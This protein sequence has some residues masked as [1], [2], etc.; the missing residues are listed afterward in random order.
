MKVAV[1]IFSLFLSVCQAQ[2]KYEMIFPDSIGWNV[3][4]E[5]QALEFTIRTSSDTIPF[6]SIEGKGNTGI[7]FDSLGNFYWKPSYDLVNRVEQSRD[8]TVIFEASWKNGQRS[9]QT[10]TFTVNHT[11]RPPTVDDLP[12][13]Y[14][15]QSAKNTYQ[16]SG[17]L[18]HDPDGDPLVFR[19]VPS[20]MPEGSSLSSQ[21]LFTWTPSR[22]QFAMLKNNP[23][24][25]DFLVEDQPGKAQTTGHIKIMQTQLDLP[26]EILIVPSDTLFTIKEDETLDLK[27]YV[28]DP[29]GDDNIRQTD[30]VTSDTRVPSSSLVQHTPL[31]YEFTWK[32]GYDFVEE[33]DS[34]KEVLFTFFALDLSNNRVQK[35][36]TVRVLD[37]VNMEEKDALQFQKYRNSLI[38]AQQLLTILDANQKKLN[39][40]YKKAKKGKKKRSILNASLGAATGFSPVII[41]NPNDAKIASGVGGTTVLT[42][43]TLEATEVIGKSK[44]DIMDKIKTNIDIRN[45]VQSSGDEFARNYALKSA[46]RS[47]EFDKDIDKLREVLNDQRLVLLELNAYQR[48]DN[49]ND[50]DIRKMFPDFNEEE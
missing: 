37:A 13:F 24:V 21:G 6:Y 40:E 41:G 39:D 22:N 9:R 14:V 27:I 38:A 49:V 28:S 1:F 30:F 29:N 45:K 42:L 8:F 4:Q 47:E 16:I 35:Q 43:N 20:M 44:D 2:S 34:V 5:G 10:V 50:R 33:V 32:P 3:L 36:V 12:V 46:R 23:L 26:P 17:D 18:V 25:V 31:Q 11:N 7:E 15:R 48:N 19:S